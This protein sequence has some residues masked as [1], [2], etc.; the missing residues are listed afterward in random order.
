MQR[1]LVLAICF[2][3][4]FAGAAD[5]ERLEGH[6]GPIMGVDVAP[7][8]QSVLTASFDNS[9]GFWKMESGAVTWLEGHE[10]AVKTA[11]FIGNG[12]AASGGDDF[13][14]D[15]WD[16]AT[17]ARL[18][19]LEGHKGKIMS[20]AASLDG[21]LLASASWDGTIGIWDVETGEL[22]RFLTGHSANVNDVVFTRS[23]ELI[24]ASYDGTIRTWDVATGKQTR[25]LVRHGF[26]VNTLILNETAG[27]LAYGAVDGSTRA[28]DLDG[29]ELADLT[30]ERRPVLAMAA[31]TDLTHIAVG[32]GQGFIMVVDTSDWS[33]VRD[34]KAAK[35]GP[36]WALAYS[37]DGQ[38]ILAGGIDP[39]VSI[40][41]IAKGANITQMAEKTPDFHRQPRTMSNG[42][43]QFQRKC[44]VCHSL[45]DPDA[46]MAGPSLIGV[47]GRTAGK[48]DG[49]RFSPAM[50]QSDLI[51]TAET[52]DKLFDLGPDNY[53]PGSK[54]PMQRMTSAQDR[55]DLIEFLRENTAE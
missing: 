36:I 5:F 22:K 51:W 17:G 24:S 2:A 20:V 3:P 6:G 9:V 28:I 14:I 34:F 40:F 4:F 8:G 50:A 54:M 29:E 47:F 18:H 42:E 52:I 35:N 32:D 1:Q 31:D 16:V 44:S 37:A 46:R 48:L 53:V 12:K 33:I 25:I 30:L 39:G 26:G 11:K 38:R 55:R 23:S 43:R 10:A 21:T 19:R 15:I 49:Y 45:S 7:D 41:P 27:W 13:F